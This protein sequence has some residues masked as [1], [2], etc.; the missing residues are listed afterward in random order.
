MQLPIMIWLTFL[1]LIDLT[2]TTLPGE[3]GAA[4][5]GSTFARSISNESSYS[6]PGSATSFT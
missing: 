2:V 4:A 6:L 5:S 3:C 1:P